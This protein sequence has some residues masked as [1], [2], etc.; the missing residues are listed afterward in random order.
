MRLAVI[1]DGGSEIGYG[2]LMR[3]NSLAQEALANGDEVTYLTRTPKETESVVGS[4]VT[5]VETETHDRAVRWVHENSVDAIVTDSYDV[6]TEL[7]KRL[8]RITSLAVISDDTRHALSCDI[9]INGNAH[10]PELD[11]EW[12]D[13]E[14]EWLLGTD[15]LLMRKMFRELAD[16]TPPW[17]D[18]PERALV[19]FGGSD[20]NNVTPDV[21]RAFDG[22]DLS[23]DVIIGP[24]FE[25]EDEI[26]TAVQETD[27][28]FDCLRDPDNL[29]RR[30]FE[31][32]LA[33]SAT[34][35]TVYE[36]LV[37]GT[38]TIGMP[39]AANQRLIANALE[40]TILTCRR[41]GEITDNICLLV[42]DLASKTAMRKTMRETGRNM[43]DGDGTRRVY[44]K[45]E[46]SGG[47]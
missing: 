20:V 1:A 13:D 19:T 10:A 32:D 35:S 7:Q 29:P 2:H 44:E 14:P 41:D 3:T 5:V 43:V 22:F 9:A 18:P 40:G 31:A 47:Y 8:S 28:E 33:V 38:P 46:T 25:N 37:T 24:G 23:V 6:D 42:H 30:M 17:R 39:Q 45:L 15:Y 26:K 34:G 27:A 16:E 4:D 36:L 11:Y 12:L 21:I